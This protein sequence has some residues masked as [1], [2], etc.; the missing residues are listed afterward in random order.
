MFVS[1]VQHSKA[2][3][4]LLGFLSSTFSHQGGL[5]FMDVLWSLGLVP[6]PLFY[7]RYSNGS[8]LFLSIAQWGRYYF[9]HSIHE[10][11]EGWRGQVTSQ[12]VKHPRFKLSPF[13][14]KAWIHGHRSQ[15]LSN[16]SYWHMDS[17]GIP[18]GLVIK[19]RSTGM[20]KGLSLTIF[21]WNAWLV[22]YLTQYY[23]WA[24]QMKFWVN[25][26]TLFQ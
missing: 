23:R 14:S 2:E 5:C 15:S 13:G 7:R 12:S 21:T 9:P 8:H 6:E 10:K 1:S 4:L 17:S 20:G 11:T 24:I 22:N 3:F 16:T 26:V 18:Q 25:S 19:I